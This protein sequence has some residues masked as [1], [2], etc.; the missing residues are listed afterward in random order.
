[1]RVV[2]FKIEPSLLEK[3]DLYA[4]NHG[5]QRSEVIRLAIER[6]IREE[7]LAED[8]KLQA[9]VTKGDKL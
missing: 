8:K 7:L 4:I 6:L 9:V 2:S 1:M 3:L 5:M